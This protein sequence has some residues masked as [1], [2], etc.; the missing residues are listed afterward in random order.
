MLLPLVAIVI[1]L[2]VIVAMAMR[3][4]PKPTYNYVITPRNSPC[5]TPANPKTILFVRGFA[6]DKKLTYPMDLYKHIRD[7]FIGRDE[8]TVTWFEYTA[9][10]I[11]SDVYQRLRVEIERVDP[12]ILM[13]HSMGGLLSFKYMNDELES[14][15]K[16]ENLPSV[17][18]M[19]AALEVTDN[20][21]YNVLGALPKVILNNMKVP[22][23]FAF[24]ASRLNDEGNIL[25]TNFT[26]T[27]A[28]QTYDAKMWQSKSPEESIRKLERMRA[29][30]ISA[31]DDTFLPLATDT[32]TGLRN[33]NLVNYALIEG[34]HE[35]FTTR[36]DSSKFYEVFYAML[37]SI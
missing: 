8:Y 17:F 4:P 11:L 23:E 12:D 33:S 13:G 7:W 35:A 1:L 3:S 22:L 32:I 16:L 18:L 14:G 20:T 28:R 24:P 25:N 36:K 31:D 9:D 29:T 21:V 5:A 27:R 19:M 15:T 34:K 30:I 10:D 6:S 2:I 26:P 37:K